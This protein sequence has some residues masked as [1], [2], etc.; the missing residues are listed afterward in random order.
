MQ[1][2]RTAKALLKFSN[3]TRER[4]F[5]FVLQQGEAPPG[6]CAPCIWL[7]GGETASLTR[8]RRE[9]EMPNIRVGFVHSF[10]KHSKNRVVCSDAA[11]WYRLALKAEDCADT[12]GPDLAVHTLLTNAMINAKKRVSGPSE[13]EQ[14]SILYFSKLGRLL[15][16][17]YSALH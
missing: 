15:E 1:L 10:G 5:V 11:V 4:V 6:P 3:Q 9:L 8:L 12:Y 13:R 14:D 16:P 7:E 17:V 2:N